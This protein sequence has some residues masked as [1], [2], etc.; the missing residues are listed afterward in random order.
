MFRLPIIK[1][2]NYSNV[3]G[4]EWDVTHAAPEVTRIGKDSL[5]DSLPIQSKMKRCTLLDPG[6]V[7]YYTHANDATLKADG[8]PANLSGTDGQVMVEIPE[9]WRKGETEGNTRKAF[10]SEDYFPGAH[11]VPKMYVSAYKASLDRVNSKLSSVVNTTPDFRGGGNQ[12]VWD[13]QPNSQL[14]KPVTDTSRDDFRIYAQNRGRN[15]F[16]MDYQARKTIFWLITCEFATRNHQDPSALGEG[17]TNIN[18]GNWSDFNGYY[19]L[20]DCGLTNSLGNNTGEVPVVLQEF[21]AAG[22]TFNTQVNS[23][24]GIENFFGDI[25]EWTN[26]VNV[27]VGDL[28]AEVFVPDSFGMKYAGNLAIN[29]GYISDILFGKDL[30]ILPADTA[31]AS[32]TTYFS[33]YYYQNFDSK[34]LRGLP[35]GGSAFNGSSA[36]SACANS[37]FAPSYTYAYF[38]SRLCFFAR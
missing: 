24:R 31:G 4:I 34:G 2:N 35:F 29:N 22:Q 8:T 7:N 14:G 9:H 36:G 17:P 11:F 15:W 16:D 20:Y 10:F 30:D 27:E 6:A 19:P 25:W 28:A 18:S 33:D 21:P 23:Y 5:H 13:G 12:D 1:S 3:Y 37:Y 38:G 32:S 26:N